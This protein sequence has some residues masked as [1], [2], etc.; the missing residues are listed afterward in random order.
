MSSVFLSGILKKNKQKRNIQLCSF[1]SLCATHWKWATVRKRNSCLRSS[2][3][4]LEIRTSLAEAVIPFQSRFTVPVTIAAKIIK[5]FQVRGA[6][7]ILPGC[8]RKSKCN[9]R[10]TRR[11]I[12]MVDKKARKHPNTFLLNFEV[13]GNDFHGRRP[14]IKNN[15]TKKTKDLKNNKIK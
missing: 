10:L 1:V 11:I 4:H 14:N 12:W 9:S 13:K 15:T 7:V 6:V 5:K 8:G 3:R 2:Q